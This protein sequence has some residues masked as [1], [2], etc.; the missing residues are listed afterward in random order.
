MKKLT[1]AD[2]LRFPLLAVLML[3]ASVRIAAADSLTVQ[4]DRNTEPEVDGYVVHVGSQPSTYTQTFDVG[5][6]DTFTLTTVVPGQRYCFAVTAYD[7]S[8]T[9]GFSN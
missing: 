4:W 9:S 6:T 8:I 7:G 1:C 5:N 2:S 3:M